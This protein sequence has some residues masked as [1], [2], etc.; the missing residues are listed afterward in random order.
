MPLDEPRNGLPR[1]SVL[2]SISNDDCRIC[3][4]EGW[5]CEHHQDT[6]WGDGDGC[7]GGAGA[8]CRCNP[9]YNPSTQPRDDVE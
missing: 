5:V 9:L 7:C 6:P 8:P 3:K 4:G 2:A 1:I